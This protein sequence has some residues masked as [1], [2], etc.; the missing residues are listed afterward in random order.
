MWPN[1]IKSAYIQPLGG[2]KC[3]FEIFTLRF[4]HIRT[5]NFQ[6][7]HC[8]LFWYGKS[9]IS[10]WKRETY[11]VPGF[12]ILN[13]K[14]VFAFLCISIL[15]SVFCILSI[16]IF[17][18]TPSEKIRR[19]LLPNLKIRTDSAVRGSLFQN[20]DQFGDPW[21]PASLLKIRTNLAVH[22]SLF[23]NSDQFGGPWI[24]ASLFKDS[25]PFVLVLVF[26]RVP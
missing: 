25:D 23:N 22:G 3:P 24:P 10:N 13:T 18:R 4:G 2:E 19:S 15:G 7:D 8:N 5:I 11:F 9:L 1:Y 16:F 6:I 12:L 14:T 26:V 20:A 21:I 17:S